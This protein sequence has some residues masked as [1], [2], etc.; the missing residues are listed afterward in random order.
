MKR[1]LYLI[2]PLLIFALLFSACSPT[3]KDNYENT[4]AYFQI[5]FINSDFEMTESTSDK[6]DYVRAYKVNVTDKERKKLIKHFKSFENGEF[7]KIP[8]A[9]NNFDILCDTLIEDFGSYKAVN[10]GYFALYN[11]TGHKLQAKLNFDTL[12][13]FDFDFYRALIFDV[14]TNT[15]YIYDYSAT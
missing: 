10:E 11:T 3:E 12:A 8:N 9:Q 7:V 5:D 1:L 2:T 14:D 13:N 15:L 4:L 6:A